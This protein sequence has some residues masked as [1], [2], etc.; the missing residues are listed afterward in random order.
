[1]GRRDNKREK[2]RDDTILSTLV[3]HRHHGRLYEA[4]VL[5]N[6]STTITRDGIWLA[7]ADWNGRAL[8]TG[9]HELHPD[10]DVSIEILNALAAAIE[11]SDHERRSRRG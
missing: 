3:S 5:R 11:E 1:M 7:N 4:E 8:D 9:L 10:T 2:R 6:G